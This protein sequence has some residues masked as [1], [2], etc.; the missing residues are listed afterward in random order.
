[1]R[2]EGSRVG[3]GVVEKWVDVVER[4]TAKAMQARR[5]QSMSQR[6]QSMRPLHPPPAVVQKQQIPIQRYGT[7]SPS[8][9]EPIPKRRLTFQSR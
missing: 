7:G 8:C 1:M 2:G 6:R 3:H 5:Q 9:L 4:E